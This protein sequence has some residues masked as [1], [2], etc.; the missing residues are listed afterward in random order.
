MWPTAVY[1]I[2]RSSPIAPTTTSPELR[3]IRTER[4]SP[5]VRLISAAYDGKLALEV[6]GGVTGTL[7]VVLVADRRPEQ[8]HDPVAGELVDRALE[9]MDARAQHREEA[10]HDR[11]PGLGVGRLGELHRAR[12]VGEQHGH[13]LALALERARGQRGSSRRGAPGSRGA[14]RARPGGAG[15]GIG[16]LQRLAASVA[17]SL[18]RRVLATA[19]ARTAARRGQLRPAL[20]AEPCS[21][22]VLVAAGRAGHTRRSSARQRG[23]SSWRVRDCW[24]P[25]QRCVARTLLMA[26]PPD[27]SCRWRHG[28]RPC[29]RRWSSFLGRSR[30]RPDPAWRSGRLSGGS[31]AA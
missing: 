20:P 10:L 13:L 7:R 19:R 9:P 31:R 16:G 6:Q 3:P 21:V 30:R 28:R 22:D 29:A 8:G 27:A 5:S 26:V 24:A 2:A 1:A 25:A 14:R 23:A 4:L 15:R 12:H 18:S 11:L 17:E